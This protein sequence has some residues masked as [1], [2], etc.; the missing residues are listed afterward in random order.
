MPGL[1][2]RLAC[3]RHHRWRRRATALV[4][5]GV[6]R[7]HWRQAFARRWSGS[8]LPLAVRHLGRDAVAS[9]SSCARWRGPA[10]SKANQTGGPSSFRCCRIRGV[11]AGSCRS[12]HSPAGQRRTGMRCSS[13][14]AE[15]L[16]GIRMLW[17]TPTLRELVDA[18]YYALRRAVGDLAGRGRRARRLP[19]SALR[20][21]ARRD[22]T[23]ARIDRSRVRALSGLRPAV[24][25]DV[26]DPLRAAARRAGGVPRRGRDALAA[27]VSGATRRRDRGDVDAHVGGRSIAAY[28]RQ[29]APAFRMLGRHAHDGCVRSAIAAG[30][31]A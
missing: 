16:T 18:F 12:S 15:D 11:R 28:S 3:R 14:G 30:A 4:V 31:R 2:L 22:R 27:R 1:R 24:S 23:G 19:P 13:Q 21:V 8:P 26:H 9:C 20:G 25:G 10:C 7:G 17:T 6:L 29:E 5:V